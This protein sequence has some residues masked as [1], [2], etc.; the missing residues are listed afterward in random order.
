MTLKE[1]KTSLKS[2]ETVKSLAGNKVAL[3]SGKQTTDFHLFFYSSGSNPSVSSQGQY[4]NIWCHLH[5]LSDPTPNRSQKSPLT[6]HLPT[7]FIIPASNTIRHS[8]R[9]HPLSGLGKQVSQLK[10]FTTF[11]SPPNSSLQ[12]Y[13]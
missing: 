2:P 6:S 7:L 3:Q 11:S 12:S 13:S 1:S 5:F 10:S 9:T 8:L 4:H